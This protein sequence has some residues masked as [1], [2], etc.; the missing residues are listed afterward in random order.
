[1][2]GGLNFGFA[3][4]RHGEMPMLLQLSTRA[5]FGAPSLVAGLHVV[6]AGSQLAQLRRAACVCLAK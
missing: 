4:R 5:G 6:F 1:L 2:S 3:S